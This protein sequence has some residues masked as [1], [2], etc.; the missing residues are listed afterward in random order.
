MLGIPASAIGFVTACISR[1][2]VAF[3]GFRT[4]SFR[5]GAGDAWKR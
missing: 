1:V 4:M 2:L 5:S 3:V